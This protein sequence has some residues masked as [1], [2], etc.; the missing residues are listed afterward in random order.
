MSNNV[1]VVTIDEQKVVK[2][3]I[4]LTIVLSILFAGLNYFLQP[5]FSFSILRFILGVAIYLIVSL[6]LVIANELLNILGYRYRCKVARESIS[7]SIHLEKGLIYSKTSKKIKNGHYQSVFLTSFSITGII[8]LALGFAIGSYPLLLASASFIAGGLA[9]F[10][11][12][13]KLQ[14]F[15][16]DCLV[17]DIPE[18]FSVY[19][20]QDNEKQTS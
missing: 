19:V 2:Q 9:N 17:Q 4:I 18:D 8:P 15:P 11:G 20:Y 13:S 5:E 3:T 6:L 10:I 16:D 7:L 1:K 12:I 14:K